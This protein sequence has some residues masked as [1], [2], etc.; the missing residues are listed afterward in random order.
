MEILKTI[1]KVAK[2]EAGARMILNRD[3]FRPEE[4]ALKIGVSLRTLATYRKKGMI[5]WFKQGGC[6]FISQDAID[7]FK[8]NKGMI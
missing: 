5:D 3:L 6:V 1:E 7:D 4:A 8:N 2:K